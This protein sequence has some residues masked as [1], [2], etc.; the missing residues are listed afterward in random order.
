MNWHLCL[1]NCKISQKNRQEKKRQKKCLFCNDRNVTVPE[2]EQVF[3][4]LFPWNI[5]MKWHTENKK[6]HPTY[7][8]SLTPTSCSARQGLFC[9]QGRTETSSP[10]PGL[11]A[12][13]SL[14]PHCSHP[15]TAVTAVEPG[16]HSVTAAWFN[17][18]HHSDTAA[19]GGVLY[20]HCHGRYALFSPCKSHTFLKTESLIIIQRKKTCFPTSFSLSPFT[21]LAPWHFLSYTFIVHKKIVPFL[22]T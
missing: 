14:S 15:L 16:A 12:I 17:A 18:M 11:Y 9:S 5:F 10:S 6:N 20:T 8:K 4:F 22:F 3:F 19:C 13:P 21:K 7:S 1:Q 2:N